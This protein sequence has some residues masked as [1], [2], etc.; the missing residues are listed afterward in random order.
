MSAYYIKDFSAQEIK[1]YFS[2]V[3]S[4]SIR[5]QLKAN[6]WIWNPTELYWY[7]DLSKADEEFAKSIG[8]IDGTPANSNP[9][10]SPVEMDLDAIRE[11]MVALFKNSTFRNY[12]LQQISD[13]LDSLSG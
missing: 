7:T 8:A 10:I 5:T 11:S 12:S 4:K 1:L 9:D 3:P 2:D 6:G 13:Y